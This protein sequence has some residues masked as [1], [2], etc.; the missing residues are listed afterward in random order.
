MMVLTN[1]DSKGPFRKQLDNCFEG[2][3]PESLFIL[4]LWSYPAVPKRNWLKQLRVTIITPITTAYP[5]SPTVKS[6]LKNG[7]YTKRWI[8]AQSFVQLKTK[9]K[10]SNNCS[11]KI[12]WLCLIQD[13]IIVTFFSY[14][15]LDLKVK[16]KSVPK[17]QEKKWIMETKIVLTVI[18]IWW[19]VWVFTY[20]HHWIKTKLPPF[21]VHDTHLYD[22]IYS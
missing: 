19:G 17:H 18:I 13:S 4:K 15:C 5:L 16:P 21:R 22:G 20:S 9:V 10:T 12:K 3:V 14:C 8:D 7:R 6:I 1:I 11:N 2:S